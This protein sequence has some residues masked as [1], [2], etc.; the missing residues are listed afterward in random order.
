MHFDSLPSLWFGLSLPAIVLLYLFKRKYVDTRVSSHMLWNRVLKDMEANRPWQK[1]RNRLLMIIQLLAAALLV[2][3]LM[4]PWMWSQRSAKAHVVIVLD[5]SASMTASILSPDG[6][7]ESRFE[8]AKRMIADWA[9]DEAP[10]SAITLLTMGEQA[11]VLLSRESSPDKLRAALD[12]IQPAYGKTAYKEAMSLAAA[13]TRSDPDSEIRLFTDGQFA[14]PVTDLSFAVPV[15]V[16]RVEAADGAASSGN[17]SVSQFGVKSAR[18]AGGT[19]T[20]VASV[21]NWGDTPKQIEVSLYAGGELADVRTVAVEPGKQASVY[22]ERLASADW[23]KLDIGRGDSLLM[24]NVSYAFLEGDRPKKVLLVGSGNLFLEK[25]LQLAGAEVTKLAPDGAAAWIRSQKADNSPD[26]VVVD[27][28]A[29]PVLASAEWGKWLSSKPVW[30]IR[31]G[32]EGKETAVPA[33][34][35]SIEEHPVSR[36]VKLQDTH[37]ANVYQPGK[38]DWGKPIVSAKDV[39]LIYA[40][41]E[42]G[43]PRLLIAFSLQQSD[44]PLRSEFP[45]L[46]Q[47]ALG[48]LTAAQGGSLGKAVAGE[49]KEIAM[50]PDAFSAKWISAESGHTDSEAEK[51]SGMIAS[52]QTVPS[53]PGLY[54]LEEQD[55]SG[56]TIRVRW[57]GAAADSRESGPGQSELRFTHT[58]A[59]SGDAGES[60][61][62]GEER[63]APL[64]LWRWIVVLIL[65]VLVWEWGVYRRGTSV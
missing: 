59:A 40:G 4:Q 47:N 23:Y 65:A 18:D 41:A 46:V 42:N 38:V 56:K 49:R 33:G 36:Y 1:L 30:Y 15:T 13:M 26:V 28:V 20:A 3:A 10:D 37:V 43:Q 8:R 14:E 27:S 9:K 22:F 39:P 11:E 21:K 48:W 63:G 31:S 24:D 45:V 12:P 34:T 25:A 64:A 55:E 17:V 53:L 57:L 5:R 16:E 60:A 62:T 58:S 44:L 29:D 54:R 19:V 7:T 32:Y 50:S 35:Y 52:M 6:A 61:Q 51:S 2:L